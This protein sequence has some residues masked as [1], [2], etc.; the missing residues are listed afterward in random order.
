MLISTNKTSTQNIFKK[1]TI[2][3]S[4]KIEFVNQENDSSMIH[5]ADRGDAKEDKHVARSEL[6]R[7]SSRI[8][9]D[10]PRW[11]EERVDAAAGY[12]LCDGLFV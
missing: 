3:L 1:L 10:Q 6:L 5:T 8:Q 9:R 11:P 12:G 2:F 4:H 7:C